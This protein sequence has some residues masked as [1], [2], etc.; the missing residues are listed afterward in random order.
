MLKSQLS[1]Y[2]DWLEKLVDYYA[3]KKGEYIWLVDI[4]HSVTDLQKSVRILDSIY[5]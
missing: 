2:R 5:S 4:I 1:S 3:I